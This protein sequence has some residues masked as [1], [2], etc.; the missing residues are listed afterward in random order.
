VR[1]ERHSQGVVRPFLDGLLPE[2]ESRLAVAKDFNALASDS[3]ALIRAVG[4]DCAGAVVIQPADEPPPPPAST[5]TAERL[6]ESQIEG[7]VANL[8]TAPLGVD[9]RVRISLGGVQEKLLLTRMPDGAWG[10]PVDG[11]PTTHILK[12]EVPR[13][14]RTVENEAM[15]MRIARHIGLPVAAVETTVIGTRTLL[16]VERYDRNVRKDGT[17]ERIHQEDFCQATATL[18]D[19]KYQDRGGPSLRRIAGLL[20]AAASPGSLEAL[21]KAVTMNVIIGNGDAH[22][23]NFSLLHE[24]SGALTLA[25]LY[26][27]LCTLR[28]GDDRLAMYIDDVQK[29]DRVT[30]ERII[31]EAVAWGLSK[32]R[33]AQIVNDLLHKVPGAIVAARDETDGVPDD[34]MATIERQLA[35]LQS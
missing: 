5:L 23:K 17:V 18:L 12:P 13:F 11:T 1:P 4:R 16:V 15:C 10:R 6:D 3:Y 20:Q 31:S 32:N 33:A 14:P 24:P 29:M 8:R 28:Y 27:L 34:M 2:G 22:A 30:S 35:R 7:L 21:L 26:D 25:P 19:K 9:A